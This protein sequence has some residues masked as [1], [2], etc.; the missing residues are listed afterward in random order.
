MHR[1]LRRV[2]AAGLDA[3]PQVL[4]TDDRGREI[5]TYLSGRIVD[6][7][8]ELMTDG[9]LVA[10]VAWI[11]RLHD[12]LD[13]ALDGDEAAGPW[14]WFDVPDATVLGHNDIA[15]YNLCFEGDALVGVFDWDLAGPTTPAIEL[16]QLAWSGVPLYRERPAAEVARRLELL[17]S[18]YGGP[19]PREV[20]DAV[21]RVKRIG[22]AGIRGWIANGDPA[23]AA[24]AAVGEPEATERS[25]DALIAR[26]P[27]IEEELS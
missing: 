12:A 9:Q 5:L 3:V 10:A 22:I 24:Q 25:L 8:E 4:G 7:D 6:V 16:A 20:L 11:R 21:V 13:G 14:R 17:A 15:P 23:G 1:V 2:R 27:S 26:R 19:S 18:T